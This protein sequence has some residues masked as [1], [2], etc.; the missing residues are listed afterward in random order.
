MPDMENYFAPIPPSKTWKYAKREQELRF[1]LPAPPDDLEQF[2][3][4]SIHDLYLNGSR[5]RLRKTISEHQTIFKLSKKIPLPEPN[6]QWISTIYLS[7]AEYNLFSILPGDQLRKK[8]FSLKRDEG[9]DMG[10][11]E[12]VIGTEKM[13]ILEIEYDDANMDNLPPP[14]PG[15]ISLHDKVEYAGHLLAKRYQQRMNQIK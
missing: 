11:D 1:L 5:M 15:A 7:E 2:P 13:W 4:K 10:V 3:C 6:S 9:M 14:F 12:I 8:R